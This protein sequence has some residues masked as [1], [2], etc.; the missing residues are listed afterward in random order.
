MK[1]ILFC[2]VLFGVSLKCCL[3]VKFAYRIHG[4]STLY[5]SVNNPIALGIEYI[6]LW[7][8]STS[9]HTRCVDTKMRPAIFSVVIPYDDTIL[10]CADFDSASHLRCGQSCVIDESRVEFSAQLSD[11]RN[12]PAEYPGQPTAIYVSTC[13]IDARTTYPWPTQLLAIY[14]VLLLCYSIVQSTFLVQ[15]AL[16]LIPVIVVAALLHYLALIP[17]V[18]LVRL[19]RW[20]AFFVRPPD[21]LSLV[22]FALMFVLFCVDF[23]IFVLGILAVSFACVISLELPEK[24][25]I[26]WATI[27]QGIERYLRT[28]QLRYHQLP[29]AEMQ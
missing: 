29:Q 24:F 17:A 1:E 19:G 4:D 12:L 8:A 18:F 7:N 13:I 21:D 3:S 15:H 27:Y 9:N 14:A 5:D 20:V 23:V 28:W 2:F 6:E 10:N 25:Q 11:C 26:A 16:H 22:A